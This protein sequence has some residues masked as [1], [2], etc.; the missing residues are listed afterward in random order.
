[1]TKKFSVTF[2]RW[3]EAALNAGDTDQRGVVI[4]EV[5]LCE[6]IQYG[7]EF[8]RHPY[9]ANCEANNSN[10]D[11]VRWLTFYDWN[12]GTAENFET[13]IE[14]QRSLHIP[15]HVTAASRRRIARLFK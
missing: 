4:E 6:A 15:D 12:H 13:G 8:G 10:P 5:S 11:N 14:E 2:E 9:S 7:L 1:M 3:D